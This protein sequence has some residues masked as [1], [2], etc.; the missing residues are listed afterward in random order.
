M[1]TKR[2]FLEQR[3]ARIKTRILAYEDAV[4]ALVSGGVRS[5]RIDTGQTIQWVT[6][7]DITSLQDTL[8]R[9]LNQLCTLEAKLN[10]L[11]GGGSIIV[12]PA[13]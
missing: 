10:G 9:L 12:G 6:T 13:F 2:E 7:N 5:Y 8:D 11:D 3:I 1:T 4:D